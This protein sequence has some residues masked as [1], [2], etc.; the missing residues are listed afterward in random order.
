VR[1]SSVEDTAA[2][3]G[4]EAAHFKATSR[5]LQVDGLRPGKPEEMM[6]SEILDRFANGR[7]DL[8]SLKSM[9]ENLDL[10]GA[11]PHGHWRLSEFLIERN[12]DANRADASTGET[13]L[14]A[15]ARGPVE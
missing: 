10:S 7:T 2:S 11:A 12:A 3:A 15:A 8:E 1:Y 14:H 5:L 6:S 13:P 4:A 9:G